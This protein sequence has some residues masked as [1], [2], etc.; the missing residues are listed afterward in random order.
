MVTK[1]Y[2][3][4][5]TIFLISFIIIAFS[6][7]MPKLLFEAEDF[8]MERE[9]YKIPRKISKID[10]ESEKIY[11]VKALHELY[12]NTIITLSE[13]EMVCYDGS[14]YKK[15]ISKNK[16][17]YEEVVEAEKEKLLIKSN[18]ELN[19][20]KSEINKLEDSNI[21]EKSDLVIANTKYTITNYGTNYTEEYL[22]DSLNLLID[23]YRMNIQIEN[24]TGKIIKISFPKHKLKSNI[25]KK[26]ILENYIKYLDLYIIDDWKYN[27]Q[28]IETCLNLDCLQSEKSQ[29]LA[30][31]VETEE[32][33]VISIQTM[34]RYEDLI[35]DLQRYNS[36]TN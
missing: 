16:R 17:V 12:D 19:K 15:F 36:D 25:D 10:V 11:L 5:C 8:A 2:I 14:D 20:I 30:L 29:L 33:Y 18:N 34:Y 9:I 32:N 22:I 4:I 7:I 3:K 23:N 21:L 1:K 35:S 27:N 24:K 13:K 6:L 31:I 26:E 28:P